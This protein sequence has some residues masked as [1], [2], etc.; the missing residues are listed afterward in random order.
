MIYVLLQAPENGYMILAQATSQKHFVM[1]DNGWIE[2][3]TGSYIEMMELRHA[4]ENQDNSDIIE[5]YSE[6]NKSLVITTE[7]GLNAILKNEPDYLNDKE[8]L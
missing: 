8:F 5:L 7:E 4:L 6:I 3:D 1:I 2:V